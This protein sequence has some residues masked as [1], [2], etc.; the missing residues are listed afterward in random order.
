MNIE[1]VLNEKHEL[2]RR[3]CKVIAPELEE[4]QKKTGVSINE[5]SCSFLFDPALEERLPIFRL[6]NVKA[7]LAL[8]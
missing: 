3:L 4:F 8:E 6:G 7:K 5:L 2:E 1:E